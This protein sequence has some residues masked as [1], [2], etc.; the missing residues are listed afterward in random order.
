[1]V[2]DTALDR[3]HL[4][5]LLSERALAHET[6]DPRRIQAIREEMERADA[7]RLQPHF[8]A[9]FF[10]AAF[11]HLGGTIREREPRRYQITHIPATIRS[12]DRQIGTGAPLPRQ[13]ER[14]T[15]EKDEINVAG[16]AR[17]EFVCPGHPL[18]DATTDV[19]LERYRGLLK[20]GALLI[21]PADPGE[22]V[23]ALC[24]LEHAIH[25]A[26]LD[27]GGNRRVV[28]RQMQFVEILA[29]GSVRAAGPA[30]YL[31]YRPASDDERTAVSAVLESDWI[32]RDLE[33]R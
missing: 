25:D 9:S 18:L 22:D 29:D 17:A 15:F 24:Y 5:Q 23:R 14:I 4:R 33:S 28:S 12:R 7:R 26:R 32:R 31:D 6:L 19:I 3:E 13:Y 2:V 11:E 8:I 21:D 16:K 30:P 1:Q 10:R 27:R 20:R